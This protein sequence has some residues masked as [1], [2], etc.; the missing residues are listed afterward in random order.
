MT[1]P[2]LI[3]ALKRMGSDLDSIEDDMG[4]CPYHIRESITLLALQCYSIS[5]RAEKEDGDEVPDTQRG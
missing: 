1:K 5:D 4:D 3:A 2:E